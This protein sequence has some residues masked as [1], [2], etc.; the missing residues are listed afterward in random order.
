MGNKVT[1]QH[2]ADAAG[3]SKYVVSKSLSGKSGVNPATRERVRQTAEKLGYRL[4]SRRPRGVDEDFVE[5]R[6]RAFRAG[7]SSGMQKSN[8]I[9][10]LP[11][12][13][14]QER[15]SAY[16][17]RIID[18]I[19][20]ELERMGSDQIVITDKTGE[21]LHTILKKVQIDGFIGVGEISTDVLHEIGRLKVPVV[22]IDHSEPLVDA[23]EL[24]ANNRESIYSLTNH[25]IALGHR[26]IRF[27]GNIGYARSFRS[28]WNGYREALGQHGLS[29]RIDD[30]L[31]QL[32]GNNRSEHESEIREVLKREL[33]D[34][35][36]ATHFPTALVCANDAIAISAMN[37]LAALK[38]RVPM[39]IS[40]TG[41]D[42][43]EDSNYTMPP[44]TTVSVEKEA[45]GRRAVQVLLT[46]MENR[47]FPSETIYLRAS[48]IH[49]DSIGVAP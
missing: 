22:L 49:R 15:G 4:S 8:V 16:W 26:S 5:R 39:D 44:L 25:L 42:N 27:V 17:G 34:R 30:P 3:V 18:G 28:R 14:H 31:V 40:V 48:L 36:S 32:R 23:T 21:N 9:V 37:A 24:F 1:M 2:I 12:V 13:R 41:F 10:L 6:G 29:W 45:M 33:R 47:E 43:I 20:L 11:N 19:G 46:R 38:L 35:T 7:D